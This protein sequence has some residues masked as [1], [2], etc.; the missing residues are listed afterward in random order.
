[1]M[2]AMRQTIQPQGTGWP[3]KRTGQRRIKKLDAGQRASRHTLNPVIGKLGD[4]D[5]YKN[6]CRLAPDRKI[7]HPL[8]G[9]DADIP[10]NHQSQT[11]LAKRHTFEQ[12]LEQAQCTQ[13]EKADGKRH[14][15]HPVNCHHQ[16]KLGPPPTHVHG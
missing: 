7:A 11:V 16:Y 2:M 9:Q 3:E 5:Q 4:T 13:E 8:V 6:P 12:I 15:E 14:K 1:M 10:H